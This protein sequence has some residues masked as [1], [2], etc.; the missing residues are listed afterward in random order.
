MAIKKKPINCWEFK[1][2]GREPEGTKAA[3]LGVCPASTAKSMDGMHRGDNAGR[4]CWVIAGT[5]CGGEVQGNYAVKINNCADCDFFKLVL[6]EENTNIK[7][8]TQLLETLD[9]VSRE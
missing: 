2:C 8:A 1:K 6:K 7:D 5:Y 4:S 9:I 3:E